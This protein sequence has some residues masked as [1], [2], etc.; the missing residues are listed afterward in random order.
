ME[1]TIRLVFMYCFL[2]RRNLNPLTVIFFFFYHFR[3]CIKGTL[4][5]ACEGNERQVR[6]C[7]TYTC[8]PIKATDTNKEMLPMI[9]KNLVVSKRP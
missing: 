4:G 9:V 3:I 1:I 5:R 6:Q 2:W 8:T 7:N